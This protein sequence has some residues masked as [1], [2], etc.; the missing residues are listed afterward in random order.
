MMQQL[1][2][3]STCNTHPDVAE[4]TVLLARLPVGFNGKF[5]HVTKQSWL[6]DKRINKNI[7][8]VVSSAP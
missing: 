4:A 5:L 7:E 2:Q 6:Q 1:L 8:I 3:Q